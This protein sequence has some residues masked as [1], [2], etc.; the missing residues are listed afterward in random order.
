M[1]ARSHN[2]LLV[3]SL[4]LAVAGSLTTVCMLIESYL[5]AEASAASFTALVLQGLAVAGAVVVFY[6]SCERLESRRRRHLAKFASKTSPNPRAVVSARGPRL[7]GSVTFGNAPRLPQPM[8]ERSQYPLS[9][10]GFGRAKGSALC[11]E[12]KHSWHGQ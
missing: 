2:K 11:I 4:A 10:R 1:F 12:A 7:S 9:A 6:W 3:A 5:P 8:R